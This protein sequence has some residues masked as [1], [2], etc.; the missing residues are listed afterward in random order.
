MAD[1]PLFPT[2][3]TTMRLS[4]D[5]YRRLKFRAVEESRPVAYLIS[6]AIALYLERSEVVSK[7]D[8][9]ERR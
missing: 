4:K 6:E 1:T 2:I 5:L 7:A 9:R 3:K 8:A